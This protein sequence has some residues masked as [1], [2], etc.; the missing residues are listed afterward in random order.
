MTT[1]RKTSMYGTLLSATADTIQSANRRFNKMEQCQQ[2][3][4]ASTHFKELKTGESVLCS[5]QLPLNIWEDM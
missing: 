5:L 4:E 2:I 1:P 3:K